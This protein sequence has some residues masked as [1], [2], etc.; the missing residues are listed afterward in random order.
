MLF[1]VSMRGFSQS[2][3]L[4]GSDDWEAW[5]V[6]TRIEKGSRHPLGMARLLPEKFRE[7]AGHQRE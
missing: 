4:K 6:F 7:G 2:S 3:L 1:I 5:P